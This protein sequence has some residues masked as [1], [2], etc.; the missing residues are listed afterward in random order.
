MNDLMIWKP[1]AD[2]LDIS[3]LIKKHD[4]IANSKQNNHNLISL[5]SDG[6]MFKISG[7]SGRSA[8]MIRQHKARLAESRKQ[9]SRGSVLHTV[10]VE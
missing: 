10:M 2:W 5:N 9:R 4:L 3:H 1:P 8:M 7:N 6:N